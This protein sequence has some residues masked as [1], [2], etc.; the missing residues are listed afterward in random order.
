MV[1]IVQTS[2]PTND[3]ACV[4]PLEGDQGLRATLVH[5]GFDPEVLGAVDQSRA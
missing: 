5:A 2:C 4:T 1:K 3:E